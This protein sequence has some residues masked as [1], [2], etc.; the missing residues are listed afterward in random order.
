[1]GKTLGMQFIQYMTFFEK[2]IGL[3]TVHCFSYNGAINFVIKPKFIA[4]AIGESGLNIKKLSSKLRKKVKIIPAPSGI[5]DA[6]KFI[7]TIVHPIK[8]KKLSIQN[9]EAII[10]ASPQSRAMLIGRNKVRLEELQNILKEYFGINKLKI[11][12]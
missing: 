8:F 6:E 11:I 7:A 2:L 3:R 4:R 12:Q 5:H 1:M 10:T 9:K